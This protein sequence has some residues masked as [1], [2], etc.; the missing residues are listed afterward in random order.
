MYESINNIYIDPD[1]CIYEDI[2]R[3]EGNTYKFYQSDNTTESYVLDF[4]DAILPCGDVH[5]PMIISARE[6]SVPIEKLSQ[7]RETLQSYV[8]ISGRDPSL[9]TLTLVSIMYSK[10][11]HI[12]DINLIRAIIPYLKVHM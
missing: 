10:V 3:F 4:D 8:K 6:I 11:D 7:L 1:V 12:K 2:Q 5:V 9:Q